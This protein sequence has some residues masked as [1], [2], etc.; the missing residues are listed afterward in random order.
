M[1]KPNK[2]IGLLEIH[3]DKLGVKWDSLES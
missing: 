2:I 1:K 3:G